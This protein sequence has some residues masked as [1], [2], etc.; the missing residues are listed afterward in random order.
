[1]I[2]RIRLNPF[3]RLLACRSGNFA[4]FF[5][6]LKQVAHR[7]PHGEAKDKV[8]K[9]ELGR[10]LRRALAGSAQRAG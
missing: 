8:R 6:S 1:M 3:L 4:L 2:E 9:D 7:T 10:L 5:A